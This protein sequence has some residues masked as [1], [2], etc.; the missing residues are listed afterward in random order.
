MKYLGKNFRLFRILKCPDFFKRDE[1]SGFP[2]YFKLSPLWGSLHKAPGRTLCKVLPVTQAT[3][4][5]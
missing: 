5:S 3:Y 2:M 1:P 4:P